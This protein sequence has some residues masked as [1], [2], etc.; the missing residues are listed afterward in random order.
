MPNISDKNFYHNFGLIFKGLE[1]MVNRGIE[2]W[3]H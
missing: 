2:N 3:K 1:D